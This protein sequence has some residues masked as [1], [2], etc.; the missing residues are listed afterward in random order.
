MGEL[1]RKTFERAA[2]RCS[3]LD[4]L[5]AEARAL[6]DYR[7]RL[8]GLPRALASVELGRRPIH[9]WEIEWS[10]ARLRAAKA[11]WQAGGFRRD[12]SV[13]QLRAMIHAVAEGAFH[14]LG[15]SAGSARWRR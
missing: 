2:E 12:L 8:T 10:I 15:D 5:T 9:V 3:D 11:V 14:R 7:R 4:L 13:D 1:R 6:L